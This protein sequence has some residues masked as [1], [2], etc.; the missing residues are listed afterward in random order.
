MWPV[1]V[2]GKQGVLNRNGR[3]VVFFKRLIKLFQF[4]LAGLGTPPRGISPLPE[5][6]CGKDSRR[7]DAVPKA[8]P[9]RRN[10][11]LLVQAIE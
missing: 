4:G 10:A 8:L 1:I 11:G 7:V 5:Y 3:S 6:A 2:D 9:V